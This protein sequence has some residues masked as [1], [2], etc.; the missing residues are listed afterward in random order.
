MKKVAVIIPT[1]NEKANIEPLFQELEKVNSKIKAKYEFNVI[2]VDD[3]S[4][5]GTAGRIKKQESGIKIHLLEREGKLGLGTAYIHGFKYAIKHNFDFIA[6]MDADLSHDPQVLPEMFSKLEQNEFVIGSRYIKGGS[7]P[8][9][10]LIRKAVS[11]LGNLYARLFLGF[12]INDYTGGFNGYRREVLQAIDLD[13]VKSNGYAFQI[14]M[15]YRTK[16][17]GFTF[18]EIPISFRDRTE[19]SSKFSKGIFIEAL[20]RVVKLR[21]LL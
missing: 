3:N 2:F 14:E 5:D 11:Y 4:P 17:A 12:N 10:S 9:W 18:T 8:K 20:A 16:K 19:G 15:K 1:Y 6:Q 7:L 21:I 13:K